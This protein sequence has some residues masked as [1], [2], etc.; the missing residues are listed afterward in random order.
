MFSFSLFALEKH[1]MKVLTQILA[2]ATLFLAAP[3]LVSAQDAPT[4]L[5]R[6]AT[7]TPGTS[8][9]A[10]TPEITPAKPV[11]TPAPRAI[12]TPTPKPVATPTSKTEATPA[13]AAEAKP[14]ATPK[15]K[16]AVRTEKKAAEKAPAKPSVKKE[17]SES[18]GNPVS[19]L[20]AMEKE[21]ANSAHDAATIEKMVANDFRGVTSAGKIVTKGSM[22]RDAKKNKGDSKSSTGHMDVRLYGPNVAVVVGT[23]K[24]SGKTKEGKKWSNTYRFTDTWMERDGNWQCVASQATTLKKSP[25]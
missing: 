17:P 21:W 11:E 4:T 3:L 1:K 14:T 5:R 19:K 8:P 7:P 10:P 18:G 23:A 13:P 25:D 22:L 24:E 16:A 6:D 20:R 12:E 9:V 2:T 15:E